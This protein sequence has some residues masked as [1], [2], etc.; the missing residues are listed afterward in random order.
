M[1]G[2]AFLVLIAEFRWDG[3]GEL[4]AI[5]LSANKMAKRTWRA[6]NAAEFIAALI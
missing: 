3:V 5:L 4:L 1:L 6:D 2:S